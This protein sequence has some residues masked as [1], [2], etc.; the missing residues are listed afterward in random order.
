MFKEKNITNFCFTSDHIFKNVI[1][2]INKKQKKKEKGKMFELNL[3]TNHGSF[4]LWTH[5]F[6]KEH[7]FI[8]FVYR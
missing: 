3:I 7:R 8:T 6:V 4:S 5:K 2:K 1:M